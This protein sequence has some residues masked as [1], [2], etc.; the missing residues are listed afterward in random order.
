MVKTKTLSFKAVVVIHIIYFYLFYKKRRIKNQKQ[1]R[2][3]KNN[4]IHNIA[5][6]I[7]R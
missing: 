2:L 1:K 5:E 3:D 6:N 7:G 4:T